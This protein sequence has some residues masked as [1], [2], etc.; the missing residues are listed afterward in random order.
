[1]DSQGT[2]Y[3]KLKNSVTF[4]SWRICVYILHVL[5]ANFEAE[6]VIN[7]NEKAI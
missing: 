3:V 4:K 5:V 7:D 2:K 6:N 1:M